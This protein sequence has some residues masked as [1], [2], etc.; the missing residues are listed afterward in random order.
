MILD[1]FKKL[2][3]RAT[4]H[5][6]EGR[7]RVAIVVGTDRKK[8]INTGY[9]NGGNNDKDSGMADI[10]AGYVGENP[11]YKNDRARVYI[12]GKTDPDNYFGFDRGDAVTGESAVVVFADNSYITARNIVKILTSKN[13]IILKQN[14]DIEIT[15]DGNV[16]LKSNGEISLDAGQGMSAR[17][18]TENDICV[19]IDPTTGGPILSTFLNI[20][21]GAQINNSKIKIK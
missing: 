19:G 20:P 14:G 2:I 5:V 12:S 8:E 17:I 10:V 7:N 18:L 15:S 13:H 11:D 16:N 21:L 1:T 4:D 9:G 3:R 6:I